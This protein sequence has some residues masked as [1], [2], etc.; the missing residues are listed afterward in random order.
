MSAADLEEI[1]SREVAKEREGVEGLGGGGARR[2]QF[3]IE[4]IRIHL[5]G[6]PI[7]KR[8]LAI[9]PGPEVGFHA[10]ILSHLRHVDGIIG[11]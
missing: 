11:A 1:S 10:A 4:A 8:S 2:D 6:P 5:A 3:G 7:V 9:L